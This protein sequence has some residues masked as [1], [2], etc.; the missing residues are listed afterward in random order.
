MSLCRR[1][2]FIHKVTLNGIYRLCH[3]L[4]SLVFMGA[5]QRREAEKFSSIYQRLG[6]REKKNGARRERER[7]QRGGGLPR[8]CKRAV[9]GG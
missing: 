2:S 3:A 7:E 6:Q 8:T 9:R 5:S 4:Q 1:N